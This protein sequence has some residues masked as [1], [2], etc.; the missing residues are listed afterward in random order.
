MS[1]GFCLVYRSGLEVDLNRLMSELKKIDVLVASNLEELNQVQYFDVASKS[2][3]NSDLGSIENKFREQGYC[4]FLLWFEGVSINV[5][6]SSPRAGVILEYYDISALQYENKE[7]IIDELVDRF[8]GSN[9]QDRIG[10]VASYR[11]D[12]DEN[13]WDH[14]ILDEFDEFDEFDEVEEDPDIIVINNGNEAKI[15]N[16]FESAEISQL[17]G[18]VKLKI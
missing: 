13:D 4:S 10:L 2:F 12:V 18:C 7:N 14:L 9:E 3:K 17:N 5:S 1:N 16:F 15:L 11:G 8:S 6:V